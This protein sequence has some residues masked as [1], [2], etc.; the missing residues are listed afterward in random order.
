[1]AHLPVHLDGP[2][3]LLLKTNGNAL[4]DVSSRMWA[5]LGTLKECG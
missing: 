5:M 2:E 4:R 3:R 1:L